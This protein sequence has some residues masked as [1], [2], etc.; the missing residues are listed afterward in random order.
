MVKTM[1]KMMALL[2]VLLMIVVGLSVVVQAKSDEEM[3]SRTGFLERIRNRFRDIFGVCRGNSED[4]LEGTLGH[5]A[6]F[7]EINDTELHF[8]PNWYI[9]TAISSYDYDRD[10][11]NETIIEEI[12]GLTSQT[13]SVEGCLHSDNWMSVYK[14]NGIEYREPGE[15]IWNAQHQF[16]NRQNQ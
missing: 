6:R 2:T 3:Y 12:D 16:R 10:G 15:P 4:Y 1:K 8:G 11:T 7:F 9:H 13:I 14:I 5:G